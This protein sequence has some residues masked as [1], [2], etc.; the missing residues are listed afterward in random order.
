MNEEQ[1]TLMEASKLLQINYSSAKSVI[2]TYKSKG[3]ILKTDLHPKKKPIP[4]SQQSEVCPPSLFL[5]RV[6]PVPVLASSKMPASIPVLFPVRPPTSLLVPPPAPM[7][8]W[9]STRPAAGS[10]DAS[11]SMLC[12]TQQGA[13]TTIR[14]PQLF[15]FKTYSEQIAHSCQVRFGLKKQL[16]EHAALKKLPPPNEVR[17][18]GLKRLKTLAECEN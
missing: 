6:L 4:N 8:V 1:L 10:S 12:V 9:L 16:A 17:E 7:P 18:L 13:L 11:T 2:H 5:P 3:R 14:Q 15:N